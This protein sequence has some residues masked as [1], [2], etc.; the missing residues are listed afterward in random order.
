[1]TSSTDV[2]IVLGQADAIKEVHSV[3]KQALE[4]SQQFMS[5]ETEDMRKKEKDT[6]K[7]FEAETRIEGEGGQRKGGNPEAR[8]KG[9]GRKQPGEESSSSEGALIDIT[10]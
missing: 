5:Q 10:V 9:K 4:L 1:M 2:N 7:E 6:V 8:K 3:R